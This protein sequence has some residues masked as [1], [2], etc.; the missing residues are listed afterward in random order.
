MKKQPVYFGIEKNQLQSESWAWEL[1]VKLD[2][3]YLQAGDAPKTR[4]I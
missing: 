3:I 2:S 1:G 4:E